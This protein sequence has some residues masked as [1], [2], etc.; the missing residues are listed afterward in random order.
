[1]DILLPG[2]YRG[3]GAAGYPGGNNGFNLPFGYL[4]GNPIFSLP[5]I[6]FSI[7]LALKYQNWLIFNGSIRKRVFEWLK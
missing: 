6:Q 7:A 4:P 5:D 2:N 3:G 1:M